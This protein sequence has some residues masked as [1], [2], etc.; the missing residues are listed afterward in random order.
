MNLYCIRH[1]DSGNYLKVRSGASFWDGADTP[2]QIRL[3]NLRGARAF[4]SSWVRGPVVKVYNGSSYEFPCYGGEE[5]TYAPE[6]CGRTKSM[7]EIIPVEL[8]F[9]DPI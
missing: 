1:R 6:P 4:V 3:F 2:E 7:L 5:Y 9:G 8:M